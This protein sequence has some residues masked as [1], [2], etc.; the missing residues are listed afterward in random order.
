M[1]A[2]SKY[3]NNFTSGPDRLSWG[4]LKEIIKNLVCLD[5]ILNITNEY[6]NLGHWPLHFKVSMSIIIPKP[7][8][9]SYDTSKIFRPIILLNM[10]GKL[11]E[12]VISKRLQFQALFNNTIHSC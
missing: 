10:L 1:S 5:N 11:I 12:K 4:H 7:N 2:I 8:K 9:A 3:S 6:I